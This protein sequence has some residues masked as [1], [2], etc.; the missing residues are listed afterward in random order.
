MCRPGR[1]GELVEG[2]SARPESGFGAL[3]QRL[4][5]KVWDLLLAKA[6]TLGEPFFGVG[7]TDKSFGGVPIDGSWL[8][9]YHERGCA[10]VGLW[11]SSWAA[12]SP[13][14]GFYRRPRRTAVFLIAY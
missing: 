14:R 7:L 4:R 13:P 1:V 12:R 3:V 2:P 6:L 10:G 11:P 9:I 8:S 5:Q